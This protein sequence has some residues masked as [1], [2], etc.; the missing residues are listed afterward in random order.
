MDVEVH[1]PWEKTGRANL[2][3]QGLQSLHRTLSPCRQSE[4]KD[5]VV[6][7]GIW[8]VNLIIL[9]SPS[10]NNFSLDFLKKWKSTNNK[11]ELWIILLYDRKHTLCDQS[12]KGK[13]NT[14]SYVPYSPGHFGLTVFPQASSPKNR[15][16][17]GLPLPLPG[18]NMFD[19]L[20]ESSLHPTVNTEVE[21]LCLVRR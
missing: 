11:F 5:L 21:N 2:E 17:A 14:Y 3:V 4:V 12:L 6:G 13:T 8:L 19:C 20:A 16:P 7:Q 9:T 15:S 1:Q 10:Q 18:I